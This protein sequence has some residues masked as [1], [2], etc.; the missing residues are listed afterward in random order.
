MSIEDDLIL[1]KIFNTYVDELVE[2]KD[3]KRLEYLACSNKYFLIVPTFVGLKS[4]FYNER[5]L[6]R[7]SKDYISFFH[8]TI[9]RHARNEFLLD[10][11]LA[12]WKEV[13]PK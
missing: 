4:R 2:G 3:T 9:E 13:K 1:K 12:N 11:M 8:Y 10:Y 6:K 5:I 7:L